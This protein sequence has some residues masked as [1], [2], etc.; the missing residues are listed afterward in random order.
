MTSSPPVTE[1]PAKKPQANPLTQGAKLGVT[2]CA[3]CLTFVVLAVIV[4]V[5]LFAVA[6]HH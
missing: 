2:G 1:S 4:V 3:G 5:V 6:G